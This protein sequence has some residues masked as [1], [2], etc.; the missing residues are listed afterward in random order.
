[1]P[2]IT[3]LVRGRSEIEFSQS[4]LGVLIVYCYCYNCRE[5]YGIFTL[6]L[7]SI[8]GCATWPVGSQFSDQRFNL[9]HSSENYEVFLLIT[10]Q[11]C[12][13]NTFLISHHLPEP[14][15]HLHLYQRNGSILAWEILWTEKPGGLRS[16]G[17]QRVRHE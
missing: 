15:C 1:M 12:L 3:Q 11:N 10:I 2:K 4:S 7:S 6:F 17:S 9:G 13:T 16:I 5:I 8:L 14:F